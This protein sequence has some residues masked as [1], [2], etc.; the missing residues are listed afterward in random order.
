MWIGVDG[1]VSACCPEL[2]LR[3]EVRRVVFSTSSS[4]GSY[5]ACVSTNMACVRPPVLPPW[6][7]AHPVA[8]VPRRPRVRESERERCSAQG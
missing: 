6:P 7:G 5:H 2:R 3:A 1:A 4:R 8:C